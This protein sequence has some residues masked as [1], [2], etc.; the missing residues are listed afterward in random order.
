MQQAALHNPRSPLP[1]ARRFSLGH[2]AAHVVLLALM[3]GL[4]G[5]GL[6]YFALLPWLS[7][8]AGK[9]WLQATPGS[10]IFYVTTATAA[11]I[12][13]ALWVTAVYFLSKL[14]APRHERDRFLSA[15]PRG[16]RLA[17]PS[18][19]VAAWLVLGATLLAWFLGGT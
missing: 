12:A 16:L 19:L 4:L 3:L 2:F 17:H 5:S 7:G 14:A 6:A 1:R 8:T 10:G 13:L 18:L 9:W 15:L 11:L